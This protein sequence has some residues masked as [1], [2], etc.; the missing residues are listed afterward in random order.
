MHANFTHV[1]RVSDIMQ[2]GIT[3]MPASG[4]LDAFAKTV[5][6][7]PK[8][9]H[10][11]VH[12]GGRIVGLVGRAAAVEAL[13]RP[14][15]A[16]TIGQASNTQFVVVRADAMLADLLGEMNAKGVSIAL[17]AADTKVSSVADILGVVTEHETGEAMVRSVDLFCD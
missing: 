12:D 4:T 15:S 5:L 14:H 7:H 3:A 17:V 10:F 2:S 9:S 1:K 16:K 6:E 13:D 8:Q 11:L